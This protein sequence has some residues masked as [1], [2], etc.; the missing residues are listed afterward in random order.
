MVMREKVSGY[1]ATTRGAENYLAMLS[2]QETAKRRGMSYFSAIKLCLADRA[3]EIV[4]APE[5]V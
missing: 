4:L 1:F 5:V 2:L 3:E